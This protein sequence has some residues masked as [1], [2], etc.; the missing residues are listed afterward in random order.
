MPSPS[1]FSDAW[2]D[3]RAATSCA[4]TQ[5][6]ALPGG[7]S[8]LKIAC[9]VSPPAPTSITYRDFAPASGTDAGA[10][11]HSGAVRQTAAD[12]KVTKSSAT[13]TSATRCAAIRISR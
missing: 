3:V 8:A 7:Q 12:A 13:V 1:F 5:Y 6:P 11:W 10:V 9:T 2:N 4:V